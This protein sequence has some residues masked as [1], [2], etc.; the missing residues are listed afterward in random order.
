MIKRGDKKTSGISHVLQLPKMAR[1]V[2][3]PGPSGRV[4]VVPSVSGA[5]PVGNRGNILVMTVR[6][7]GVDDPKQRL[8]YCGEQEREG[9]QDYGSILQ[10]HP[11]ELSLRVFFGTCQRKWGV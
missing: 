1:C 2:Q 8:H 10:V 7:G 4:S 11:R 3:D 6:G 9:R 5:L